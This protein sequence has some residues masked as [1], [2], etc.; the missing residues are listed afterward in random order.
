M[1]TRDDML[2][3]IADDYRRTSGQTGLDRPDARVLDAIAAVPRDRFVAASQRGLAWSN[4]ALNIPC[5]QTI[6]QPYIVALMTDVLA[7]EPG[8]RVLEVG[9]GSGYQTAV[10]LQMGA[11]VWGVEL[12]DELVRAATE[13]LT[14]LGYEGF[15]IRSGDGSEGWLEHAPFDR[16]LIAA[17][18][19]RIPEPL[20]DQLAA[21]GRMVIPLDAGFEGQLLTLVTKAADGR[22]Q[23]RALLPVRFVPF[24]RGPRP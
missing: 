2:R 20:L 10:L 6:S 22:T 8:M 5:G 13:R 12:H 18:A 9:T 7:I 16:I 24:V 3:E 21:G 11:R 14:D 15:A 17:A 19:R 23:R 1:T 4:Q